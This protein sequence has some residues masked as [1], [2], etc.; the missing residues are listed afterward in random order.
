MIVRWWVV[1]L[2]FL[3]ACGV[4]LNMML[5]KFARIHDWRVFACDAGLGTFAAL[6]I[7]SK[8]RI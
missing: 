3:Y 6:L 7:R 5:A 8:K 2:A 1:Y 4:I